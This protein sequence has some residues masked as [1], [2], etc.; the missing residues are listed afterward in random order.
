MYFLKFLSNFSHAKL[1]YFLKYLS[2]FSYAKLSYFL[3]YLSNFSYAKLSYF[4]KY[5]SNFSYAK[6]SYFLK[7]LSNFSYA[8]L[9]VKRASSRN[10]LVGGAKPCIAFADTQGGCCSLSGVSIYP[11]GAM[12]RIGLVSYWSARGVISMYKARSCSRM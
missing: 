7:Y 10:P 12:P 2:N 5:L 8:K 3:K 9:S 4:L 11:H 1:S 6:L